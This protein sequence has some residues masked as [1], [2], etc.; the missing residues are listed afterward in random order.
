M[1]NTIFAGFVWAFGLCVGSFLNV[2]IYRLPLGKSLSTPRRSFCPNC[3]TTLAAIDNIPVLSWL[4]LGARCRTCRMPISVQYPLVEAATGLVFLLT[5]RLLA[6]SG[7]SA[8]ISNFTYEL[9]WPLLLA[10]LTLVAVMAACTGMD[11]VSYMIDTRVTNFGVVVGLALLAIWPRPAALV[12]TA[13]HPIAAGLAAAMIVGIAWLLITAPREAPES[14]PP[15]AGDPEPTAPIESHETVDSNFVQSVAVE[16]RTSAAVGVIGVL[17]MFAVGGWLISTIVVP[18]E[19]PPPP[20]H[21]WAT[22]AALSAL[23]VAMVVAGSQSRHVDTEIA[24]AIEN[25]GASARRTALLEFA[26]LLPAIL[27][28]VGVGVTAYRVPAVLETWAHLVR[29][30]PFAS[31]VPIAGLVYSLV[32]VCVA[33]SAGWFLRIFFTLVFGR[34]AFGVGDIYILAAAG[35]VGGWEIALLGL[36][37]SVGLATVGWLLSLL[38]KSALIIPFGPWLALGFVAALWLQRPAGDV[39]AVY[40]DS[41]EIAWNE[42][43]EMLMLLGAILLA[44]TAVALVV[45]RFARQMIEPVPDSRTPEAAVVT[46]DAATSPPDSTNTSALSQGLPASETEIAPNESNEAKDNPTIEP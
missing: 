21:D 4:V 29:W 33:V 37:F 43:P 3:G 13:S 27:V 9:D 8:S 34:E 20:Q 28:G 1:L 46:M 10:W 39:A 42:R 16:S 44:G 25:E 12:P 22:I 36:L 40:R 11:F 14:A 38:F 35:A 26:W 45:A 15:S 24:V 31:Y 2:V 18:S 17:A 6:V 7:A 30:S 19:I 32:G 23:F 41:L 5:F